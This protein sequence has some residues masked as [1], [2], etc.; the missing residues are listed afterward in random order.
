MVMSTCPN[1]STQNEAG[2]PGW[3][4]RPGGGG[5]VL[6]CLTARLLAKGSSSCLPGERSDR[7]AGGLRAW[8]LE[9]GLPQY[10]SYG[11]RQGAVLV[12]GTLQWCSL[13]SAACATTVNSGK[14]LGA[15]WGGKSG[16]AA[17]GGRRPAVVI[18]RSCSAFPPVRSC[19]YFPVLIYL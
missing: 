19:I 5:C 11:Y 13:Q 2:N 1:R 14:T 7:R 18:S 16:Q 9:E 8:G 4:G 3:V 15:P 17:A 6:S 10:A 12:A